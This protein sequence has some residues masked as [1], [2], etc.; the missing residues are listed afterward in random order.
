MIWFILNLVKILDSDYDGLRMF[1][2]T[3]TNN[4]HY[5]HFIVVFSQFFIL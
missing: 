3:L 5:S 1:F 2:S 4:N